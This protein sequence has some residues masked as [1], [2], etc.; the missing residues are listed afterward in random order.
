M[1]SLT[2]LILWLL[3]AHSSSLNLKPTRWLKIITLSKGP[4]NNQ[5]DQGFLWFPRKECTDDLAATKI[6]LVLHTSHAAISTKYPP[7][8]RTPNVIQF[9][10]TQPRNYEFKNLTQMLNVFLLRYTPAPH[11]I[12]STVKAHPWFL[13]TRNGRKSDNCLFVKL[14]SNKLSSETNDS[15]VQPN[16]ATFLFSSYIFRLKSTILKP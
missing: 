14:K 4:S 3:Y 15:M 2:D 11:S 9:F 12:L 13:L 1:C 5:I 8:S 6:Y 7:T 16:K 10:I